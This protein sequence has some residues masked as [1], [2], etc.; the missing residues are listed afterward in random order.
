ML[1]VNVGQQARR[2]G[3]GEEHGRVRLRQ[4]AVGLETAHMRRDRHETSDARAFRIRQDL[5]QAAGKVG[6]IEMAMAVDQHGR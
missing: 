6:E 2:R 5:R 1:T 4:G 3:P